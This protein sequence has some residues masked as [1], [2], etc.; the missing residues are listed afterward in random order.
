MRRRHFPLGGVFQQPLEGR[1]SP[2]RE[3]HIEPDRLLIYRVVGNEL[4]LVR[5][6]SQSELFREK[7]PL[8]RKSFTPHSE[9]GH[10]AHVF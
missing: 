9:M 1:S 6:C 4:R 2:H 3:A 5:P 7:S 8:D 10:S